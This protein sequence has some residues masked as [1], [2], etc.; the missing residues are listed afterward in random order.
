M[1]VYDVSLTDRKSMVC[2]HTLPSPPER[3]KLFN[4]V[5]SEAVPKECSSAPRCG[6]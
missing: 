6:W 4:K 5:L 2:V 1:I 3:N